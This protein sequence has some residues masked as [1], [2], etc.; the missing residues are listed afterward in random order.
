[1]FTYFFTEN[2]KSLDEIEFYRGRVN[3]ITRVRGV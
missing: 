3:Y 1:M 2:Y